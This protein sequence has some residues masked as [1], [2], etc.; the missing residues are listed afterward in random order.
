M[1]QQVTLYSPF[2]KTSEIQNWCRTNIGTRATGGD[3]VTERSP[4]CVEFFCNRDVW[5]FAIEKDAAWFA[6]RW[7]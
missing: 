6:L 1:I 7:T 2:G 5:Y 4:W 3:Q